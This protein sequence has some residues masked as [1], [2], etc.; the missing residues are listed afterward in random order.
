MHFSLMGAALALC[1]AAVVIARKKRG[2]AWMKKHVFLSI[3]GAFAALIAL[4]MMF[5]FK[6]SMGYPHF[7]SP[8]SIGGLVT[9]ALLF[10]MPVL[11]NMMLSGK[12]GLRNTHRIQGR[13]VIV[14][15][16]ITATFGALQ[17][18]LS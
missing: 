4:L 1:A 10:I 13:V 7:Q 11:G 5:Y 2:A 12:K 15:M 16:A 14:L 6:S 18:I 3:A 17:V 9:L 8:H